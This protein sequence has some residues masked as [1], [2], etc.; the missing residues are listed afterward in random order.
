MVGGA[1]S[2]CPL[3]GAD[4]EGVVLNGRAVG[5]FAVHDHHVDGR[6]CHRYTKN[7]VHFPSNIVAAAVRHPDARPTA[8]TQRYSSIV[9]IGP[10]DQEILTRGSIHA[11]RLRHVIPT[12]CRRRGEL[13]MSISEKLSGGTDYLRSSGLNRAGAKN[14]PS[15]S[16][17]SGVKPEKRP[18]NLVESGHAS[19]RTTCATPGLRRHPRCRADVGARIPDIGSHDR[20]GGRLRVV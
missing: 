11:Q 6:W 12:T 13:M 10:R 18:V 4:V 8:H 2:G 15:P 3:G 1:R 9:K 20:G 7:D 16:L 19:D 17:E 14:P 5:L